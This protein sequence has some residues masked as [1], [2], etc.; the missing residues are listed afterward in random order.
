MAPI[1]PSLSALALA[2]ERAEAH[3]AALETTAP[4]YDGNVPGY[5]AALSHCWSILDQIADTRATSLADLRIL[6]RAFNWSARLLDDE[7]YRNPSEGEM[8]IVRQLVTGLLD[9]KMK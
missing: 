9:E 1:H 7:P 5:D 8:K 2:L 6:A 4:S 3:R